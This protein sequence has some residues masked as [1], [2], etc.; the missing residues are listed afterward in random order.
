MLDDVHDWDKLQT[1]VYLDERL[2]SAQRNADR[3]RLGK[4]EYYRSAV[5]PAPHSNPLKSKTS[6]HTSASDWRCGGAHHEATRDTG[7]HPNNLW[8]AETQGQPYC[9][10]S[11]H[12]HTP[13]LD[14]NERKGNHSDV[15]LK[16]TNAPTQDYSPE[17]SVSCE[18]KPDNISTPSRALNHNISNS[19]LPHSTNGELRT[20]RIASNT[21]CASFSE[22]NKNFRL[23]RQVRRRISQ[24]QKRLQQVFHSTGWVTSTNSDYQRTLMGM[25][26][27]VLQLS[28]FVILESETTWL[29]VGVNI[30][31]LSVFR[32]V[33]D[34]WPYLTHNSRTALWML[35]VWPKVR[36]KQ[37]TNVIE[38]TGQTKCRIHSPCLPGH[39]I[40]VEKATASSTINQRCQSYR[41]KDH[42]RCHPKYRRVQGEVQ[43]QGYSITS[44]GRSIKVKVNVKPQTSRRNLFVE[45]H[46]SRETHWQQ[47]DDIPSVGNWNISRGVRTT[48]KWLYGI[49]RKW[50]RTKQQLH[51]TRK[52]QLQVAKGVLD[53][54]RTLTNQEPAIIITVFEDKFRIIPRRE[55]ITTYFH[56]DIPRAI[57]AS[58]SDRAFASH[59]TF[60]K[61]SIQPRDRRT[62][63]LNGQV[64][65]QTMQAENRSQGQHL[66]R[67]G[68]E[69][70]IATTSSTHGEHWSEVYVL[71]DTSQFTKLQFQLQT[72]KY[73]RHPKHQRVPGDVQVKIGIV[74]PAKP[75]PTAGRDN[76]FLDVSSSTNVPSIPIT[77]VVTTT[78]RDSKR[79]LAKWP[80][81]AEL[82][83]ASLQ[84]ILEPTE[85][86]QLNRSVQLNT[87]L[88]GVPGHIFI[89]HIAVSHIIL[90]GNTQTSLLDL[91]LTVARTEV[92]LSI[93]RHRRHVIQA[94]GSDP[95]A[96]SIVIEVLTNMKRVL[97]ERNQRTG[98]MRKHDDPIWDSSINIHSMVEINIV[99]DNEK[100]YSDLRGKNPQPDTVSRANDPT[101]SITHQKEGH[102]DQHHQYHSYFGNNSP[103]TTKAGSLC[104]RCTMKPP[105]ICASP[106]RHSGTP[107]IHNI[108]FPDESVSQE[109]CWHQ[110]EDLP[111]LLVSQLFVLRISNIRNALKLVEKWNTVCP[112][113]IPRKRFYRVHRGIQGM[114]RRLRTTQRSQR[115][116]TV[117]TRCRLTIRIKTLSILNAAFEELGTHSGREDIATI[118]FYHISPFTSALAN[119]RL[120]NFVVRQALL[121]VQ[122]SRIPEILTASL[123]VISRLR[124]RQQSLQRIRCLPWLEFLRQFTPE[125]GISL[126]TVGSWNVT[127]PVH[128]PGKEFCSICTRSQ[129]MKRR[130]CSIR[131][132]RQ[133]RVMHDP[134]RLAIITRAQII[135]NSTFEE[136]GATGRDDITTF[137]HHIPSF[138]LTLGDNEL[139]ESLVH[140][141][142]HRFRNSRSPGI[143]TML[144]DRTASFTIQQQDLQGIRRSPRSEFLRQLILES[145]DFH[146]FSTCCW[147]AIIAE[148]S[149]EKEES[150]LLLEYH[151]KSVAL[152]IASPKLNF[153]EKAEHNQSN[154]N[155][156][157]VSGSN[158]VPGELFSI[159]I[160]VSSSFISG[161][162]ETSFLACSTSLALAASGPSVDDTK[163]LSLKRRIHAPGDETDNTEASKPCQKLNTISSVNGMKAG[164]I[165]QQNDGAHHQYRSRFGNGSHELAAHADFQLRSMQP[166][167]SSTRISLEPNL[168]AYSYGNHFEFTV[169]V[170]SEHSSTHP[171]TVVTVPHRASKPDFNLILN[172]SMNEKSVH[173]GIPEHGEP[174]PPWVEDV[175]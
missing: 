98:S 116:R 42:N 167:A 152:N 85:C 101:I 72:Q 6:C 109:T 78:E 63:N 65:G 128:I 175:E 134:C 145:T 49:R 130:P 59:D 170:N 11:R 160:A 50:H 47:E 53:L 132:Y 111:Y 25:R 150:K 94:S 35:S 89:V 58:R 96:V 90:S 10:A 23:P 126:T 88:N 55:F 80:Q 48:Q 115:I 144:Q 56:L 31:H 129:R 4:M 135:P 77:L 140:R 107:C 79:L 54:H 51:A 8:V 38:Q 165:R 9:Q 141:A 64:I 166:R 131:K 19:I 103:T 173:D 17:T 18:G 159:L 75:N 57:I 155:V 86:D 153:P 28:K 124:Y 117:G 16:M 122:K 149:P 67:R 157:L 61:L 24:L 43:A 100:G 120:G 112:V 84:C 97:Q 148:I 161:H 45:Q 121:E 26:K 133:I 92:H 12:S 169:I 27:Y 29:Q 22:K 136:L 82:D 83:T 125:I 37:T 71:F 69:D 158:G 74:I 81:S 142:S 15:K 73:F 21:P 7:Q 162:T 32:K 164:S 40:E 113:P 172:P 66:V 147:F 44:P 171:L 3:A 36:I 106:K 139:G 60:H 146:S 102:G 14:N 119:R 68:R 143:T 93:A 91:A 154:Q 99:Q 174:C 76:R 137:L 138:T 110:G 118:F 114:K 70:K 20:F 108:L 13:G 39:G 104:H 168:G 52:D 105:S 95:E 34:S 2:L 41:W 30:L 1:C 62:I 123:D 33:L 151:P 46:L 127:S 163:V 87:S 5:P 156:L